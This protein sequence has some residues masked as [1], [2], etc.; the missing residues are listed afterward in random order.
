M[1]NNNT[2]FSSVATVDKPRS[3]FDRPSVTK[4]TFNV[5]DL[6]PFYIDEVLPGDTFKV[7]TNKLVRL[8]T[9]I[10]PFMDDLYLDT[11]YFFVPMRLVWDK[12]REFF[13]ENTQGHWYPTVDYSIP[14]LSAANN[15]D[16]TSGTLWDYFGLPIRDKGAKDAFSVSVLP[17]RAYGLI[18]NE[19]FR[20]QNLQDPV[21]VR[22]DSTTISGD[23]NDPTRGGF[24]LKAAK[25]HDYFTSCLP[26]PQ[27]G[28][29]VDIPIDPIMVG[30]IDNRSFFDEYGTGHMASTNWKAASMPGYSVTNGVHPLYLDTR[31]IDSSPK[32]FS[33]KAG[34]ATVTTAATNLDVFPDNLATV[35]SVGFSINE[36][37]NAFQLQRFYELSAR[38]GSRYRELTLSFFGVSNPDARV[39]IPEYL[40]GNRINLNVNQVVQNSGSTSTSPLGET[41]AYSLT[42]DTNEDFVKSFSEHGFVIGLTV[43]RYSHSY[44]NNIPKMFSR[45]NMTDFYFPVFA[46]IGEQPVLSKEI[47]ADGSADD[48]LVFGYQEAWAEYRYKP[49]TV[50]SEM[51]SNIDRSLDVWHFADNYAQRPTLSS[52]WISEDKS[53]VDRV[54]AVKSSVSNQLFGDFYVENNTTRVMPLYSI[55][56]LI[57]HN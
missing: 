44:Q 39:Q 19:F 37:R 30:P 42:T 20:D 12:S 7:K 55:P 46:N 49:D 6:V 3:T 47:Y 26:S 45:K 33:F 13:G 11:Y 8:Q 40:G 34:N 57:D 48:D 35:P 15:V 22:L 43:C 14:Q 31:L 53:N 5:G 52:S 9:P 36:L 29:S 25:L 10:T 56:G 51:R 23:V 18:W 2:L 24:P 1:R 28:P 21:L 27:K 17:F 38:G 4:T 16:V 41:G 32:D 50:T 54:L